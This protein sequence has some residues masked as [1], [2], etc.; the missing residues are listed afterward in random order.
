MTA[1]ATEVAGLPTAPPDRP[2]L[3]LLDTRPDGPPLDGR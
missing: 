1:P 3:V 2:P